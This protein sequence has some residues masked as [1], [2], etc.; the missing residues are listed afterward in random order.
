VTTSATADDPRALLR[1]AF[2]AAVRAVHPD[3]CVPPHVPLPAD[4]HTVVIAAG[5]AAT[6]MAAAFCARYPAAVSGVVATSR[7]RPSEGPALPGIALVEAGHPVPDEGSIA[8]AAAA[9][10][11]LRG[12][13][14]GD[15]VVALLSGGGS[16]LMAMPAPGI[17]L[18]DKQDVTRQLLT[19]GA[20]IAEINC[21]RRKLSAVKGGRLACAAAPASVAVLA[22]SDVPGDEIA[23]IASGPF[24]PDATTLADAR[25]VL[26]RYGCRVNAAVRRL[27]D[28]A[29]N[30][31]PKPG[32]PRLARVQ[33]LLCA[34]SADA[35]RAAAAVLE[36]AGFRPLLLDD[37]VDAPAR[38]LAQE[39]A[40]LA[41][42]HRARCEKVALITGGET[43]VRVGNPA[44]RGGR[45]AEYL[46]ALGVALGSAA[47]VWALAADTDGIDG[48]EDNAGAL[49]APDSLERAR[50]RGLDP[51]ALLATNCAWDFFAAL[52]DLV[53]TGPTGTNAN[54]LRIVL[55]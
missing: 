51:A 54:D 15:R 45:N 32:D 39:H 33:T 29:A 31:T 26:G 11:A 28:D 24:S 47:G 1:A 55:T 22:I 6:G 12:L 48:T 30:E 37:A 50:C 44:G 3:H 18:A 36:G 4:G 42:G 27:L 38:V 8:A 19:S 13:A 35:L 52:D 16:A 49:L 7:R 34:R 2:A 25:A 9:L 17:S 43:T 53:V 23:D 40:R 14:A 41:L 10:R 21:V 5:K 46:L 20:T